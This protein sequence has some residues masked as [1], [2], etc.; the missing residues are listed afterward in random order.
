MGKI[1]NLAAEE[2]DAEE[3]RADTETIRDRAW[4]RYLDLLDDTEELGIS[5][6]HWLIELKRCDLSDRL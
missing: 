3:F 1:I 4:E 2:E 6:N 5:F